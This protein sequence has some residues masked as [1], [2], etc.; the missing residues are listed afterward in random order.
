MFATVSV[1][2]SQQLALSALV[3]A[4]NV[5]RGRSPDIVEV[6]TV[7]PAVAT[8]M[9]ALGYSKLTPELLRALT[10]VGVVSKAA[11]GKVFGIGIQDVKHHSHQE[12]LADA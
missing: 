3:I 7:S 2:E 11:R 9:K 1:S 12:G 6:E 4:S 8:E 10:G 5:D